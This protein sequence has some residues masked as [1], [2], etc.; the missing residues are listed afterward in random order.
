MEGH[1]AEK[2]CADQPVKSQENSFET[3]K[4]LIASILLRFEKTATPS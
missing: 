4:S 3:G 2:S 1:L